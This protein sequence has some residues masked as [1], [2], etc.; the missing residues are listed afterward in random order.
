MKITVIGFWGG[1]P[2]KNEASSGYLLEYG[3]Y[4]ILLDCGSGVLSELQN[5]IQPEELDAV[6]LS[7]YH[8]DHV[9]DVGVLQHALLIQQLLSGKK[10]TV[11]IYGHSLDEFEFN[12]LT[13]KEIT[14]GIAYSPDQPIQIG[15][16]TF[17]FMQTKHPVT[18]YA[19]RIE[20]DGHVLVYT[21]DS[22]YMEE[23]VDFSKNATILLCE[24]NFYSNM[25][26]AQAGHMTAHEAGVIANKANV[27]LLI[28]THLPHYGE[29]QQLVKEAS[30]V[31]TREI[32]LARSRL[33][34]QL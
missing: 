8:P 7:H 15:P 26:G 10:K 22:A 33:E 20:V 18:C 13:Y 27:Q 3:D 16:F 6:V 19:M 29:H 17:R 24:S 11:P 14:K 34:F 4:R 21:G 32:A 12:K 30:A 31:F 5:H 1:Y 9:A 25:N 23:L 2:A 28:L